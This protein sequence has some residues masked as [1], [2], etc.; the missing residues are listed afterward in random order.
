MRGGSGGGEGG[1]RPTEGEVRWGVTGG[2]GEEGRRE[3]VGRY[4]EKHGYEEKHLL[5]K[6][7]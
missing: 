4:Y 7:F 6:L 5:S 2:G 1:K 3:E